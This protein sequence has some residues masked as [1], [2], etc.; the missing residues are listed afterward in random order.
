MVWFNC[1]AHFYTSASGLSS[2]EVDKRANTDLMRFANF[3]VLSMAFPDQAAVKLEYR[4]LK[5]RLKGAMI[6][7]PLE[8]RD[9]LRFRAPR[10]R[11][12]YC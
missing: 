6:W 9:V 4:V 12:R 7:E 1:R 3:P 5:L 11:L 2:T 10:R 8:Q